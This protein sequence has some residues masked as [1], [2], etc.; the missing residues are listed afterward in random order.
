MCTHANAHVK[1]SK[2]ILKRKIFRF[3]IYA[4]GLKMQKI[5]EFSLGRKQSVFYENE[6]LV[7]QHQFEMVSIFAKPA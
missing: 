2:R 1:V 5:S 7:T 3:E 6:A 4:L